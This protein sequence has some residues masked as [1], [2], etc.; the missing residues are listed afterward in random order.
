MIDQQQSHHEVVKCVVVGDTG[1]GK[2]RLICAR[3]CGTSYSL[4]HLMH[5]HVPTVWAID[6]YRHDLEVLE[7]SYC[8]VDKVDVSLRLWDT[9]G[10][11]GKDRRFAYGRA[12]VVLLCFSVVRPKTYYN[13]VSVWY[14]E[15]QEFCPDTPIV[16]VGCQVDL[17]HLYMDKDFIKMDKGPFFKPILEE[18][19]LT[20]KD[21]RKVAKKIGAYY[22]ESSVY[23][24]YGVEEVFTNA[25]RAALYHKRQKKFWKT[26]LRG[27]K[28]PLCQEPYLPPMPKPPPVQVPEMLMS[29]D[30]SGLLSSKAFSD[31]TLQ[32]GDVCIQAHRVCLVTASHVFCDLLIHNIGQRVENQCETPTNGA[33]TCCTSARTV[34]A[35]ERLLPLTDS[36]N[37]S[38]EVETS[39]DETS[40][41]ALNHPAFLSIQ[42]RSSEG[43][44][45]LILNSDITPAALQYVLHYLYTGRALENHTVLA[46]A[47]CAA[48]L[49]QLTDL[50]TMITN[51]ENRDQI[52]NKEFEEAFFKQRCFQLKKLVLDTGLFADVHFQVDD[53]LVPAHKALLVSS[54]DPMLAMF[55]DNFKESAAKVV[56]FPG[57]TG[58]TFK[59]LQHYLYTGQMPDSLYNVDPIDLIA[60]ANRL[61]LPNLVSHVELEVIK[62]FTASAEV[63][64]DINRDVMNLLVMAELHNAH[65]LTEWCL[66]WLTV[67]YSTVFRK[68]QRQFKTL[69]TEMQTYLT[70]HRWPPLWYLR[71]K[72]SHEK[73]LKEEDKGLGKNKMPYHLKNTQRSSSESGCLCFALRG[74]HRRELQDRSTFPQASLE[75]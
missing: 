38:M 45:L 50:V 41:I 13:L 27:I 73:A 2:T 1:T 12:D 34:D 9:F 3:A 37:S 26:Q 55:S 8:S 69:P 75:D 62:E 54:C 64:E 60:V 39:Q 58:D 51:I 24:R 65:Q 68:H 22:Y 14:P 35:S 19:I 67:Q 74:H 21:G 61:C 6:H 52:L 5:T 30:L 46:E 33:T 23:S 4:P 7:R 10:Y 40:T 56:C 59:T 42:R 31:I 72:F 71:E 29:F 36:D 70:K 53:G 49:L 20:P 11:H 16:L 15:I 44:I 32:T 57:M 66:Y 43:E 17:R 63:G 18:D 47:K 28:P 48:Q 25:V